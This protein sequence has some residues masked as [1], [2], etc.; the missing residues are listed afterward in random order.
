MLWRT[1]SLASAIAIALCFVAEG[2]SQPASGAPPIVPTVDHHQHLVSPAVAALDNRHLFKAAPVPAEIAQVIRGLEAHWNDKLALAPLF[3]ANAAV[4]T[5][6]GKW[7][8]GRDAVADF[9]SRRFRAA[10]RFVP[11]DVALSQSNARLGGNLVRGDGAEAKVIGVFALVLDKEGDRHWRIST[12]FAAFPGPPVEQTESAADLVR[13]LDEA[14][15]KR[16]V[17]LSDAYFFDSPRDAPDQISFD[18]LRAENDWTAAQVAQFPDRLVAFCSLNPLSEYAIRE[19]DRCAASGKFKG[20]KLHF[21][22]SAVDLLNPTH[23]A[24]VR[25]VVAESNRLRLPLIVHVRASMTD[26]GARHARVLLDRIV[27]AAP[28]VPFTIA[29]LWGGEAF[30]D[31]ALAIYAHAVASH[32]PRAKKLYFDIAELAVVAA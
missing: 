27:S 8:R 16:A 13:Y 3:T 17:V 25:A 28:D 22:A 9:L 19:L 18:K 21:G 6:E 12:E 14:G 4:N 2:G 24:K 29:H 30:S 15:I 20:L 5:L 26:Y 1:V 32:D 7:K 11:I 23:V 10:Y 31:E